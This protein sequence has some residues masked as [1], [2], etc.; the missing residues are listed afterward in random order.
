MRNCDR[1][2]DLSLRCSR[3]FSCLFSFLS[4]F[5]PHLVS[6]SSC[7]I[8]AVRIV[9][10]KALVP[11]I[12]CEHLLLKVKELLMLLPAPGEPFSQN[13]L[14]GTLLQIRVLLEAVSWSAV[15]K[16]DS[17]LL[18]EI[19]NK[20]WICSC[21]NYCPLTRASFL[22]IV[23]KFGPLLNKDGECSKCVHIGLLLCLF[24]VTMFYQFF[25]V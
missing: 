18:K 4:D 10:A 14:H 25:A 19:L 3:C 8:H 20:I 21:D 9:A 22:T 24:C 12:P 13:F 15:T 7:P 5:V 1:F 11:F 17:G 16:N 2:L 6:L 23:M